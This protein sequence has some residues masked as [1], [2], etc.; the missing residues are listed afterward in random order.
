MYTVHHVVAAVA[1]LI[2][3]DS[4]ANVDFSHDNRISIRGNCETNTISQAFKL[5]E[6][7]ST[8]YCSALLGSDDD[9]SSG[10]GVQIVRKRV[11]CGDDSENISDPTSGLNLS[12]L[13]TIISEAARNAS[14]A[15]E[16]RNACSCLGFVS[17]TASVAS[18]TVE[19]SHCLCALHG[20][21]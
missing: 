20:N 21:F 9:A 15:S 11:Q 8:A 4:V 7:E 5:F 6:E 13:S 18:T 17:Q 16:V 10:S 14:I 12:H 1:V 3:S 2:V 19:V